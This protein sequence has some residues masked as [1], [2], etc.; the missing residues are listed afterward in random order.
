VKY[1]LLLSEMVEATSQFLVQMTDKASHSIKILCGSQIRGPK[2]AE[3]A[4]QCK[5]VGTSAFYKSLSAKNE[6]AVVEY[7]NVSNVPTKSIGFSLLYL[8]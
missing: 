7:R 6:Y 4:L 3:Y 1:K 8:R 2:R 5:A